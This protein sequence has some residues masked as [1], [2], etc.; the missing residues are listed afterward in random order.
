MQLCSQLCLQ[1][2]SDRQSVLKM[3]SGGINCL[4]VCFIALISCTASSPV[5]N[6]FILKF[7]DI[8]E[9]ITYQYDIMTNRMTFDERCKRYAVMASMIKPN[10]KIHN[11]AVYQVSSMTEESLGSLINQFIANNELASLYM[12]AIDGLSAASVLGPPF[13]ELIQCLSQMDDTR[14][15]KFLNDEELN[16]ILELYDRTVRSA[17]AKVDLN[18]IYELSSCHRE[19]VVSLLHIFKDHIDYDSPI[20]QDLVNFGVAEPINSTQLQGQTQK[21]LM[22]HKQRQEQRRFESLK[23][24]KHRHREQERLCK[25]RVK[26]LSSPFSTL[27]GVERR[28]RRRNPRTFMGDMLDLKNRHKR[29]EED[30][31]DLLQLWSEAA[32]IYAA[33]PTPNISDNHGTIQSNEQSQS[34][35]PSRFFNQDD[36]QQRSLKSQQHK[37]LQS[38][39]LDAINQTSRTHRQET[40][41]HRSV[42]SP[43]ISSLANVEPMSSTRSVL[44]KPVNSHRRRF[45][46][47][48]HLDRFTRAKI[49]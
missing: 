10:G 11:K 45:R 25:R 30:Q 46:R 24:A 20:Y 49:T 29:S 48:R 44:Q 22:T 36:D 37:V 15:S 41:I 3:R 1:R 16:V 12:T 21:V 43:T 28:R 31:P 42:P 35:E 13:L 39:Y 47:R 38:L 8:S 6:Q 33:I 34:E 26:I 18:F 27:E 9:A 5:K 40:A 23:L 19:F 4:I 17:D 14:I 2:Q 7:D 32:P